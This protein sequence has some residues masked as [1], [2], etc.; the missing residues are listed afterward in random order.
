M[1]ENIDAL[2]TVSNVDVQY[3][4]DSSQDCEEVVI[5]TDSKSKQSVEHPRG[6]KGSWTILKPKVENFSE[7][8]VPGAV[9]PIVGEPSFTKLPK[10]Q[11]VERIS[12]IENG[13]QQCLCSHE[14]LQM[15]SSK[16]ASDPKIQRLRA[17]AIDE[18]MEETAS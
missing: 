10:M 11:S 13:S 1:L 4:H 7:Q 18:E 16:D 12:I 14:Q 2:A 17:S 15:L 3:T 8:E 6:L 5:E 9:I